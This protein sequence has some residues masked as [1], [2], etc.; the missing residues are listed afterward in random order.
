MCLRDGMSRAQTPG[1]GPEPLPELCVAGRLVRVKVTCHLQVPA[2][3]GCQDGH[4]PPGRGGDRDRVLLGTS[5]SASLAA[6][7]RAIPA[8]GTVPFQ[9]VPLRVFAAA[10][11]KL[12]SRV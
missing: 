2:L 3:P 5:G 9:P 12:L 6:R 4:L 10:E 1:A 11:L 8:T 7:V